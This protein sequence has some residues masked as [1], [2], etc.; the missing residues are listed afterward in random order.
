MGTTAL[1]KSSNYYASQ[2]SVYILLVP[3]DLSATRYIRVVSYVYYLQIHLMFAVCTCVS[4]Q[5]IWSFWNVDLRKNFKLVHVK[6][7]KIIYVTRSPVHLNRGW[8]PE[9]SL[10]VLNTQ[11]NPT[12]IR[13]VTPLQPF[14][15]QARIIYRNVYHLL[16]NICLKLV[17]NPYFWSTKRHSFSSGTFRFSTL[18]VKLCV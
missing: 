13:T 3:T 17:T 14:H 1:V 18:K 11:I 12:Y 9:T 10:S 5:L 2:S 4:L 16:I 8:E 15:G 7:T 6:R